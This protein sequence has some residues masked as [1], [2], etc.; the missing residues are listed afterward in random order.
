MTATKSPS[1]SCFMLKISFLKPR[2]YH[3]LA[4]NQFWCYPDGGQGLPCQCVLPFLPVCFRSVGS[5]AW[6]IQPGPAVAAFFGF[7][8]QISWC[9]TMCWWKY[10]HRKIFN[11]RFGYL[12]LADIL[13]FTSLPSR[14]STLTLSTNSGCSLHWKSI[15]DTLGFVC[16]LHM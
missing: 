6:R 16:G 1:F 9:Q 13:S 3:T 8:V 10:W 2:K 5:F 11:C 15:C 4:Y 12:D 7:G 14:S